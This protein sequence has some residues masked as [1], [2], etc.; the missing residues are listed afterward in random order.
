MSWIRRVWRWLLRRGP[1]GVRCDQPACDRTEPCS[2]ERS[3][4]CAH[5]DAQDGFGRRGAA[6][7]EP[8][9]EPE[10]PRLDPDERMLPQAVQVSAEDTINASFGLPAVWRCPC[11]GRPFVTELTCP[12]CG[13]TIDHDWTP[14]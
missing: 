4:W 9:P 2:A 7:H 11:G 8:E 13:R 10:D 3:G 5:P 14:E 6:I 12:R 1:E